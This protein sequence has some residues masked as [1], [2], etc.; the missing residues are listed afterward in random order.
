MAPPLGE[1]VIFPPEGCK[2]PTEG[3]RGEF[4]QKPDRGA[5][6]FWQI[7]NPAGE[8]AKLKFFWFSGKKLN[9][10]YP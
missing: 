2:C 10:A 8:K 4:R 6:K 3:L 7:Y 9:R 1:F 5:Q